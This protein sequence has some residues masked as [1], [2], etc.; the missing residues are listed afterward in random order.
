MVPG[1]EKD[2]PGNTILDRAAPGKNLVVAGF[3]NDH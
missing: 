1:V 2:V 3:D